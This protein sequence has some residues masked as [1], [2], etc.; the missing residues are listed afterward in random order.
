M[1]NVDYVFYYEPEVAYVKWC[2]RICPVCGD[3]IPIP[4]I[5]KWRY[6]RA[7]RERKKYCDGYK[8]FCSW[9]CLRIDEKEHP[10]KRSNFYNDFIAV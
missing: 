7:T 8:Y 1:L 10:K 9:K 5:N 6:K 4:D 3:I 2:T